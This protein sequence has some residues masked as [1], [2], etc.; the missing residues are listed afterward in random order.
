MQ[1][2]AHNQARPRTLAEQRAVPHAKDEARRFPDT[3][4]M[5]RSGFVL[6]STRAVSARSGSDERLSASLVGHGWQGTHQNNAV[7]QRPVDVRDSELVDIGIVL[8]VGWIVVGDVAAALV[9][10]QARAVDRAQ[11]QRQHSHPPQYGPAARARS[12]HPLQPRHCSRGER[13]RAPLPATKQ[14]YTQC[15]IAC[16]HRGRARFNVQSC[17]CTR[18]TVPVH[19]LPMLMGNRSPVSYSTQVEMFRSI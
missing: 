14:A 15:L 8:E 16:L 3:L 9:A 11:R 2:Y 5:G 10:Q 17:R 4:A 18:A 1:S 12:I 19:H 6:A 7:S 13:H